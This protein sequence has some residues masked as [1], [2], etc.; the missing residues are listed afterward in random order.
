[1]HSP[2]KRETNPAEG[3]HTT[4]PTHSQ[5][6]NP[7]PPGLEPAVLQY[8]IP[9]VPMERCS[10]RPLVEKEFVPDRGGGSDY[11][12]VEPDPRWPRLRLLLAPRGERET[13]EQYASYRR[14]IEQ[15]TC[16]HARYLGLCRLLCTHLGN[17]LKC[18]EGACR[19]NGAC[20]GIRDQDRFGIP[21]VLFPPC[22][23]LD[24]E[25]IET[26][27]QEIIAE[28]KRVRGESV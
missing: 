4:R 5:M 21:L 18:R 22:V 8:G 7:Y 10:M 27:R 24:L 2:R 12:Y 16:N 26:C 6:G 23:P 19:R 1:M 15:F 3:P 13:D 17:H 28:I 14:G 9:G 20:A 25:I 11:L